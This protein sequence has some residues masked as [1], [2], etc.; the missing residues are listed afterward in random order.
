MPLKPSH[1][2]LGNS[3]MEK[4]SA[5][6]QFLMP[7]CSEKKKPRGAVT[8]LIK[9]NQPPPPI[10][11]GNPQSLAVGPS[12]GPQ[13]LAL[14]VALEA[15]L[16]WL[17]WAA[18][19]HLGRGASGLGTAG[20]PPPPQDP[21]PRHWGLRR[22]LVPVGRC[23]SGPCREGR[24][25]C[26]ARAAE[27]LWGSRWSPCGSLWLPWPWPQGPPPTPPSPRRQWGPPERVGGTC[28]VLGCLAL[29]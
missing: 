21:K 26:A 13:C 15:P 20:P 11:P 27:R 16:A 3:D 10:P 14:G 4:K 5:L 29:G 9:Y 23:S 2:G 24:W 17:G 22:A 7:P 6:L 19:P 25:T 8:N 1:S 18:W 12:P 28:L